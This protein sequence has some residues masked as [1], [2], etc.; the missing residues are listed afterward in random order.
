MKKL[1]WA[2]ESCRTP[3]RTS[4]SP[5]ATARSERNVGMAVPYVPAGLL[6]GCRPTDRRVIKANVT[7]QRIARRIEYRHVG[8][9]RADA[10]GHVT[11]SRHEERDFARCQRRWAGGRYGWRNCVD[12]RHRG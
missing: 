3:V 2:P 5:A 4:R 7:D 8:D 11:S 1:V 10:A 12:D 9:E 6:T